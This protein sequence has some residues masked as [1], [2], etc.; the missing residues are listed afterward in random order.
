M[1]DLKIGYVKVDDFRRSW[2]NKVA[3]ADAKK[4]ATLEQLK[5]A[6]EQEVK[7]QEEIF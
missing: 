1:F 2:M 3:T 5:S 6:T 4:V 7:L